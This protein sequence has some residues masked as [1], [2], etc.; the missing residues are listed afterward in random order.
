[1]QFCSLTVTEHRLC[2][3]FDW[4]PW[5]WNM[6][7]KVAKCIAHSSFKTRLPCFFSLHNLSIIS[8]KDTKLE[9]YVPWADIIQHEKYIPV[10]SSM[11]KNCALNV[12][13]PMCEFSNSRNTC[14]NFFFALK[15]FI[16]ILLIK[17]STLLRQN[18][19]VKAN[20]YLSTPKFLGSFFLQ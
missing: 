9:L 19:Q 10:D 3:I 17:P 1:M 12:P 6:H 11:T 13:P 7:R 14:H 2:Q 5:I 15:Y 8:T 16:G 4:C 20:W 18:K